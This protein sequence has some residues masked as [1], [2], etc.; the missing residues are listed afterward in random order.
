[1][2]VRAHGITAGLL[3]ACF[4]VATAAAAQVPNTGGTGAQPQTAVTPPPSNTPAQAA[5]PQP[6]PLPAEHQPLLN[7]QLS[8]QKGVQTG[9][10]VHLQITADTAAGDELALPE[11]SLGAFEVRAKRSKVENTS[12]GKQRFVFEL[13]LL[14]VEP[15]ERELPPVELRVVTGTG[16]VGKVSTQPLKLRVAALLGNQPNA[17][18]KPPTK[19]VSVMQDD[20]TLL[21]VLGAIVAA[22]AI[23]LI[24]L[25]VSRWWKRREKKLPPPPPPRPPWE[26]AL[27][28]LAQ[29]EGEKLAALQNHTAAEFVDRVSDT[30]REYLGARFA[31]GSL[32]CDGLETTSD[33]MI[34]MLRERGV[35][36]DLLREITDFLF[37]CDLIKFAKVAANDDEVDELLVKARQ[38][39]H[40]STPAPAPVATNGTAQS[41][42]DGSQVNQNAAAGSSAAGKGLG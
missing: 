12:G 17:K 2:A 21:Y 38:V 39:V 22:G 10:V 26:V 14:A 34:G 29:L 11:Q 15:G 18:L 31:G 6:E 24:T 27:E 30:L 37:H 35:Q 4:A 25:F 19:P 16:L 40:V 36:S 3:L 13:D 28:R 7:V 33:E 42:S 1:M 5:A 32:V 41:P 20:Y 8:P 9:D 23:A